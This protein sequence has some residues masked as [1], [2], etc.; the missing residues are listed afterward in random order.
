MGK[1]GMWTW[2]MAKS[3]DITIM[4]NAWVASRC[5]ASQRKSFVGFGGIW[6]LTSVVSFSYNVFTPFFTYPNLMQAFG[7]NIDS[8][9]RA[10]DFFLRFLILGVGYGKLTVEN[11]VG[12][13]TA[14]AMRRIVCI[15]LISPREDMVESL[16][17]IFQPLYTMHYY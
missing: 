16:C 6:N 5:K 4:N 11:Q 7:I 10:K 17:S 14:M 3:E 1:T 12:G 15:S 8:C 2:K 9:T 13:E